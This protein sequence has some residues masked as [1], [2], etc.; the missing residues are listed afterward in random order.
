LRVVALPSR[1]TIGSL[2]AAPIPS[3]GDRILALALGLVALG[4]CLRTLYP[5]VGGSGD[6]IKFQY[7]GCVLGTAHTPAIRSAS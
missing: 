5:G 6:A 7:L 2:E 4:V 1:S 3:P